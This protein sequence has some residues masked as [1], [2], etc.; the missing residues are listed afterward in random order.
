MRSEQYL[1]KTLRN[2]PDIHPAFISP[3]GCSPYC[4]TCLDLCC[5]GAVNPS[6]SVA[7]RDFLS[8]IYVP[9]GEQTRAPGHRVQLR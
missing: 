6:G 2:L 1:S 4:R 9:A 3:S 8:S 7:M 5:L